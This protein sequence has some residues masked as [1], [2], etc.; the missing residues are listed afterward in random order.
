MSLTAAL[1]AIGTATGCSDPPPAP[2][3][4]EAETRKTPRCLEDTRADAVARVASDAAD[5]DLRKVEYPDLDGDGV[6]EHAWVDTWSCG[7]SGNCTEQLYLSG[8]GCPTWAGEIHGV[9]VEVLPRASGEPPDLWSFYRT[10]C[11]GAQGTAALLRLVEGQYRLVASQ[12]CPCPTPGVHI[13]AACRLRDEGSA[14]A[15]QAAAA[16]AT[17]F[18][19]PSSDEAP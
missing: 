2:A 1:I 19:T 7:A 15:Q 9:Q 4:P 11:A 10:G 3:A 13:P 17:S 16:W 14:E 18:L 6:S 5:M 12:R 8:A